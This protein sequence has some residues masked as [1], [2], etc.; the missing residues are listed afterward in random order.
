MSGWVFWALS[1]VLAAG[2]AWVIYSIF[3]PDN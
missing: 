3:G 2:F 1:A